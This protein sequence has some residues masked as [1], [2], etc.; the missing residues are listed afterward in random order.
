MPMVSAR[1]TLAKKLQIP[2]KRRKIDGANKAVLI[3]SAKVKK[4]G[5]QL[6]E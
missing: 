4:S 2:K 1:R 5:I 6:P 3:L